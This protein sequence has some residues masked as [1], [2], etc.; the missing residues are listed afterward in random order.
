M[1][2]VFMGTPPFAVPSLR[3]LAA[4][5]EV[6]GVFTRPDAIRGRGRVPVASAVKLEALAMGL[7]IFE[8][9]S[10]RHSGALDQL[11]ALGPDIV[12]VAAYGLIL[13]PAVLAVALN[14]ALNVH[15]SLLPRWRGA[16]PIAR[17]ILEGDVT[18]GVAIMRMEEGL[19]TGPWAVASEVPVD[20]LYL[21]E[22]TILLAEVGA[23][24]LL[25]TLRRVEAGTVSWHGQDDREA[26]FAAKV[27]AG[28]V[29]LGSG[30]SA[31]QAWRRVRASSDSA[32]SI[33]FVGDTRVRVLAAR[34][35]EEYPGPGRILATKRALI[36]GTAD[37]G[38]LLERIVPEGR[39]AMEGCAW[40]R[41]A[42]LDDH[43]RW[44]AP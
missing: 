12:A 35:A 15:A 16:A 27:T 44:S 20:G 25:E 42:H 24:A 8:P 2:I 13:P 26:T 14:G 32:P 19:D 5:H 18:T 21:E 30:I 23:H 4:E 33:A 10:L 6:V 37:G 9:A 36:V 29:A 38:L 11:E 39:G 17:A 3:A 34:P 41:G 1:R 31:I 22:L 40:A 7:H 28:D 43:A